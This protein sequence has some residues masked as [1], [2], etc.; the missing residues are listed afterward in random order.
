MV[1]RIGILTN[2]AS[3]AAESRQLQALRL[4]LRERGWIEGEN[5]LIEFRG[6]EGNSARLPDLAA[7]LVRRKVDLIVTRGSLFP[8]M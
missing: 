2:E 4:G 8:P 1:Y 3:D 7:D 6:V 5:I